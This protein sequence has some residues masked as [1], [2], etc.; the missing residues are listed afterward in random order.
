MTALLVWIG[1]SLLAGF[2]CGWVIGRYGYRERRVLEATHRETYRQ[3]N[4]ILAAGLA[5]SNKM[6]VRK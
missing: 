2:G 6:E 4:K 1:A 3:N 5:A